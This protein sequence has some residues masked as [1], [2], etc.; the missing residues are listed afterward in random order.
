MTARLR[1]ES[2][3]NRRLASEQLDRDRSAGA[4]SVGSLKKA[5]PGAV[6][7][8]PTGRPLA[9]P[10][11]LK[12]NE[13]TFDQSIEARIDA[14]IKMVT[15]RTPDRSDDRTASSIVK[16]NPTA[17]SISQT[18]AASRRYADKSSI[19]AID[20]FEDRPEVSGTDRYDRLGS[21]RQVPNPTPVR[22]SEQERVHLLTLNP[23]E[24]VKHRGD[25]DAEPRTS[26][27]NDLE[28]PVTSAD[29]RECGEPPLTGLLD[30][31]VLA[32]RGL[33]SQTNACEYRDLY[34]VVECERAHRARTVVRS[35]ESS[36][37]WDERFELD[38]CDV[39]H[40]A[41]LL[42]SW[43]AAQRHQL[44]YKGRVRLPSLG[45]S[46]VSAHALALKMQPKGTLYVRITYRSARV[47]FQR[48]LAGAASGSLGGSTSTP[49][50]VAPAPLFGVPLDQLITREATGLHVP[51]LMR[52]C[53]EQVEQRALTMV[54]VY[55]LCGSAVR[56]RALREALERNCWLTSLD[57]E[58]VPDVNVITGNVASLCLQFARINR[59]FRSCLC[60]LTLSLSVLLFRC[61]CQ[62]MTRSRQKV[63]ILDS[64]SDSSTLP[65]DPCLSVAP[66]SPHASSL[67]LVFTAL[68]SS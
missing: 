61:S 50:L 59:Y 3:S 29:G 6:N 44:C 11:T 22:A 7:V 21:T 47:S 39:T 10:C 51:L 38:V 58:H 46:R 19:D 42:Y 23:R 4:F 63:S 16:P 27:T 13:S 24:F 15:D 68:P 40:L 12:G 67:A 57:A 14:A 18:G 25:C 62:R 48:C 33:R 41:F 26:T 31:H 64:V 32:A 20:S 65:R 55:R 9:P 56:K 49:S 53:I 35:G 43:D 52:R 36:F 5:L 1:L 17:T 2:A 60:L 30:V 54:G 8:L 34:A 37:D 45:L 28:P 66:P